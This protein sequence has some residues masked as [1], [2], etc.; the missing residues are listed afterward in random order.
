MESLPVEWKEFEVD[1]G[2]YARADKH[3]HLANEQLEDI[4]KGKV[5]ASFMYAQARYA[6][7]LSACGFSHAA[8]M[9]AAK[10][11]TITYF[12]TQFRM[13]LVENLDDYIADFAKYMLQDTTH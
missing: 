8:E 1:P 13:M 11:E 12:T 4:S 2:F 3:I 6:A 7:W 9:E 10:E 5:S